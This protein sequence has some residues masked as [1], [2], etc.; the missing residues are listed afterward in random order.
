MLRTPVAPIHAGDR[1]RRGRSAPRAP[2]GRS[3]GRRSPRPRPRARAPRGPRARPPRRAAGCSC[4]TP[5]RRRRR[6]RSPSRARRPPGCPG[7]RSGGRPPGRRWR[8]PKTI[9]A[10][11]PRAARATRSGAVIRQERLPRVSASA[12][13]SSDV[14]ACSSSSLE[15]AIASA[16]SR[17]ASARSARSR[18]LPGR[19]RSRACARPTSRP[20]RCAPRP[21]RPGRGSSPAGGGGSRGSRRSRPCGRPPGPAGRSRGRSRGT[22]RA[23]RRSGCCA[24]PTGESASTKPS[25]VSTSPVCAYGGRAVPRPRERLQVAAAVLLV[26]VDERRERHRGLPPGD[27]ADADRP[28]AAD[29]AHVGVAQR[30][31]QLAAQ[32]RVDDLGVLVH[33][34]ERLEVVARRGAVEQRVVAAEDRPDRRELVHLGVRARPPGGCPGRRSAGRPSGLVMEAP[35]AIIAEADEC[36]CLGS[37]AADVERQ[38]RIGRAHDLRGARLHPRGDRRLLRDRR[39]RRGR[40]RRQQRRA[41]HRGGGAQDRRPAGERAA[42]GLRSRDAPRARGRARRAR[43]DLRAR[44][45]VPARGHRQAA[46]LQRRVRRRASA[47]APRAS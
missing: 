45:H 19:C 12:R 14:R 5:A 33:E 16:A 18:Q 20:P 9:I 30:R 47:R 36:N 8:M 15:W 22:S 27:A 34:H 23:T 4:G 42:P 26:A 17:S 25:S 43:R 29:E 3:R 46:R 40:G 31:A 28:D 6:R 37:G 7:P 38:G 2:C 44:R 39:G 41:G 35:K 10:P 21:T 13:S 1:D 24:R 32:V 11:R